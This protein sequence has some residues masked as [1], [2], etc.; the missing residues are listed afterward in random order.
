MRLRTIIVLSV[1]VSIGLAFMNAKDTRSFEEQ[2][3]RE[4]IVSDAQVSGGV[5]PLSTDAISEATLPQLAICTKHGLVGFDAV[6]RYGERGGRV[7]GIYGDESVFKEVLDR[8]GH[9]VVPVVAFFVENGSKEYRVRE[10]V[11]EAWKEFNASGKI[12]MK[13]SD[14][15]AEQYGL[16]AMYDLQRR[17]HEFLAEFEIVDGVARR[18]PATRIG[19]AVKNLFVGGLADLEKVLVQG[20]RL[21]SWQ[22]W[23]SAGLDA[24]VF[25]GS[26]KLVVKGI[27]AAKVAK[28]SEST[29]A[30]RATESSVSAYR[31]I[32]IIGK[33][34][35]TVAPVAFVYI[36]ITKPHLIASAG[37]WIAEQVG[38]PRAFGIFTVYLIGCTL[39]LI[40][41]RPLLRV[42]LLLFS[43]I[44]WMYHRMA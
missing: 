3:L 32:S 36:A 28:I 26:A 17:G 29:K 37:G 30:L 23:G 25:A 42:G 18:R 10:S 24:L 2:V 21:P 1:V 4:S 9:V 41:I 6:R 40:V 20:K 38:L 31:A 8:Y 44:R 15:I 22:E 7:F 35:F 39:I 34:S 14:M 16:I 19:F 27:K 5:C 11:S 33:T 43:P 13:L 12:E